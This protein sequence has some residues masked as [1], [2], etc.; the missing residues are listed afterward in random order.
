MKATQLH[1]KKRRLAE[2]FSW[3]KTHCSY[4]FVYSKSVWLM[5]KIKYSTHSQSIQVTI[6]KYKK[7]LDQ[8]NVVWLQ[9]NYEKIIL[10]NK[11]S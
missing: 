7:H 5:I 9:L 8:K 3:E 6:A 4:V 1:M 2:W 11:G 10:S